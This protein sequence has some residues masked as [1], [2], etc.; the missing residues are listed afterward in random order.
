METGISEHVFCCCILPMQTSPMFT[1]YPVKVIA[2][3]IHIE[4]MQEMLGWNGAVSLLKFEIL[5][6]KTYIIVACFSLDWK[7]GSSLSGPVQREQHPPTSTV[8]TNFICLMD[9]WRISVLGSTNVRR[10]SNLTNYVIAIGLPCLWSAFGFWKPHSNN[11]LS[12][13][14][15][16][17]SKIILHFFESIKQSDRTC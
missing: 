3:Y 6:K 10:L 9:R 5:F 11:L 16:K 14:L 8:N 15:P 17:Y 1:F 7:L 12:R 13:L 4:T 2:M